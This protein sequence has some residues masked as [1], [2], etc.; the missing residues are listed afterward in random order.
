MIEAV[1]RA[2]LSG[3][4]VMLGLWDPVDQIQILRAL[5]KAAQ[6]NF[7]TEERINQSLRRILTLKFKMKNFGA[8]GVP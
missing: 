6:R 3:Y 4:E 7:L 5:K 2:F 8:N 1:L